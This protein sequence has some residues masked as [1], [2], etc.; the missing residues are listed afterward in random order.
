MASLYLRS[1]QILPGHQE[2][3]GVAGDY[4]RIQKAIVPIWLET[5]NGDKFQLEE[6]EEAQ[7]SRFKNLLI[8]HDDVADQNVRLFV[9]DSA[10]VG[11]AKLSGNVVV[12]GGLDVNNLKTVKQC[13]AVNSRKTVSNVSGQL[14]AASASRAFLIIQ[15][16][17]SVG[18]IYVVFG[19]VAAV[20]T[21][22][23]IGPGEKL[24]FIGGI[25]PVG[26]ISAIGNAVSNSDVVVVVGGFV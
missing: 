26:E 10:R 15:N 8:S 11:S 25:V 17:H 13:S 2:S 14:V 4:V 18:S 12:P 22:I 3:V 7:I 24:E 6:G 5:E 16:K 1:F 21:G 9:G 20:D 23:E 19:A